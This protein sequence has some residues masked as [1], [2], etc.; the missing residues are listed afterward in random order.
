MLTQRRCFIGET[1]SDTIARIL[2]DEP[3]WAIVDSTAPAA[4]R[5]AIERC[6]QKDSRR[7]FHD[8]ADVR[9]ELEDALASPVPDRVSPPKRA[10][11]RSFVVGFLFLAG[12][13]V[14]IAAAAWYPRADSSEP[15]WAGTLL[16]GPSI[17]FAPRISHDGKMLAFSTLVE[18]QSQIAVMNPV[19]GNW[20]VLT[21]GND[22]GQSTL[23]WST[24]GT[25]IY[26]D[27]MSSVR[28][29]GVYS[30]PALGGEVRLLLEAA[31]SPIP[32]PDGS[33]V[34]VRLNANRAAQ[35]Y[36]FHPETSDLQP[37]N[38]VVPNVFGPSIC[39]F[40]DGRDIVFYGKSADQA[41]T[42]TPYG[43]YILNLDNNVVRPIGPAFKANITSS[44]IG[45]LG[46]TVNPIDRSVLV[47]IPNE[48]LHQLISIPFDSKRANRILL[49][50]TES[51]AGIAMAADGSLFLSQA[52]RPTVIMRSKESDA[53]VSPLAIVPKGSPTA[54]ELP[55]RGILTTAVF[56][57]R[58]RLTVVKPDAELVPF[59]ETE[60][61]THEPI[62]FAGP[63]QVAF[64]LGLTPN[65]SIGIAS[66][67]EGRLL[68]RLKVQSNDGIKSL[69][70]SPDGSTLF[71]SSEGIIW[72]I[73]TTGG[74]PTK[75]GSGD[76]VSYDPFRKDLVVYL[77][78]ASG[79]R[80]ERMALTGGVTE[81]IAKQKD[82]DVTNLVGPE[83]IRNDGKIV[84]PFSVRQSWFLGAGVFDPRTG[85]LQKVPLRYDADLF[86]L[87]WNSKNEIV[88]AGSLMRST[89]WRFHLQNR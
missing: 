1:V 76:F 29:V 61:E 74:N 80:M 18:G 45:G 50:L 85:V 22:G 9:L 5:L 10:S 55:D 8:A 75:L 64:L 52:S 44:G 56:K 23:N 69:A 62:S 21:H 16:S 19:S 42:G 65:E 33:F 39:A 35:L 2:K 11:R 58:T 38:A 47:E 24:D 32:L 13:A 20:T 46:L 12:V 3:D 51:M 88:A 36:R 41:F 73:S 84:L 82:A 17:A 53:S 72:S 28:P 87:S 6:L 4:L 49:T 14:G 43:L 54:L 48:D 79:M 67:K 34:V 25:R 15:T 59:V 83:A 31:A 40:P 71:Y 77:T 57:G 60:D 81:P 37:L 68:K 26:F 30:V 27:H 7:R 89:I 86:S 78:E 70:A 63:N 66:I